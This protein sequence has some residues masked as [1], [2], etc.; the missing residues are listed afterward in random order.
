MSQKLID[1]SSDLKRLRDEGY[2]LKI[3][4]GFLVLE[5]ILYVNN[6]KEI[7][8]GTLVMELNL[9]G[10]IAAR[11]PDHTAWFAGEYPCDHNGV[12]ITQIVNNSQTQIVGGI[13]INH[14]F[15]CYPTEPYK[16]YYEKV[17]TYETALSGP[18][19]H[20]DPSVTDRV[21]PVML[22]EEEDGSVFNYY[23]TASSRAGIS[24]VSVKLALGRVAI[25]GVGGTG[26]YVLDL[27]A[28]TPVG[29]IHLFDGDKFLNHNAFRSP[30]A[31]AVEDLEKQLAKVDYFASQYSR[32]HRHIF[33]HPNFITPEN[34][35]QLQ[36][37]DFV[38]LCMDR[39]LDKRGIVDKLVEWGMAFI[40]VGMTVY[41]VENQ[42]LGMLRVTAST[43]DKRDHIQKKIP[44]VG[45][46]ENDD[47][48]QNI[49][50]ADLNALNASL[51]V[52]KWKKLCGFYQDLE[53]EHHIT[54]DINVN[55]LNS[56]E[57]K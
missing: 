26:S 22:P 6:N 17:K 27:L 42:L 39:G 32:M 15:S 24:E 44:F 36:G 34:V 54:Y 20:I 11:P 18:A 43:S 10:N 45:G 12:P 13:E 23:D 30:G 55:Q 21:Y 1:H 48:A 47:Y 3:K 28:K 52:H 7:K 35:A 37:M 33:P 25:V 40:D 8:S 41:L 14:Y 57:Q 50:V 2:A 9:A 56:C 16:D 51:A 19:Q 31:P 53:R 49:Q 5:H 46:D 4:P 29:E 38:F